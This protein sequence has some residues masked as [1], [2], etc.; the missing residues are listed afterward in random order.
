MPSLTNVQ[1]VIDI[2]CSFDKIKKSKNLSSYNSYQNVHAVKKPAR[3]SYK[4]S[5]LR[6]VSK[7]KAAKSSYHIPEKEKKQKKYSSGSENSDDD[8]SERDSSEDEDELESS[9]D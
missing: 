4:R 2:Q 7:L 9:E 1:T 6:K 5:P 8:E 3:G